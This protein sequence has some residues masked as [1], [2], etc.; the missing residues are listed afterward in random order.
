MPPTSFTCFWFYRHIAHCLTHRFLN[1]HPSLQAIL[2]KKGADVGVQ[3]SG[4]AQL[5]FL[6]NDTINARRSGW[7]TVS[8]SLWEPCELAYLHVCVW[9]VVSAEWV[10]RRAVRKRS[11]PG[12]PCCWWRRHCPLLRLP[13]ACCRL[14]A[15]EWRLGVT[16]RAASSSPPSILKCTL[17]YL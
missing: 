12:S 16:W 5:S 6:Q 3:S 15:W 1:T 2:Q 14:Q 8:G 10:W 17:P 13:P 9:A 4:A 7:K 11:A